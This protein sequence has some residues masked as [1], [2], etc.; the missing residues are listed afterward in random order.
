MMIWHNL[1][2]FLLIK[3]SLGTKY[4]LL[5]TKYSLV[6]TKYSLVETKYS[7]PTTFVPGL[8]SLGNLFRVP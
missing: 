6:E 4:S 8:T 1:L 2:A 3:T 5:G 7:Q